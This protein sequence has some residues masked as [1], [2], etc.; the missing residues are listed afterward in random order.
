MKNIIIEP[1]NYKLNL[2]KSIKTI[3]IEN[4]KLFQLINLNID[5]SVTYVVNGNN[6]NLIKKALITYNSFQININ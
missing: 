2:D 6:Q 3:Y 1:L 4:L 5:D